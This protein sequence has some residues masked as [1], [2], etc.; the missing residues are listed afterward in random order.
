MGLPQIRSLFR[1]CIQG[2]LGAHPVCHRQQK[3]ARQPEKTPVHP[4]QKKSQK[5]KQNLKD[6]RPRRGRR[7]NPSPQ[8]EAKD[9][10]HGKKSRRKKGSP[11]SAHPDGHQEEGKGG[12]AEGVGKVVN[13]QGRLAEGMPTQPGGAKEE[14]QKAKPPGVTPDPAPQAKNRKTQ[15]CQ[16]K[17]KIVGLAH[18][19]PPQW[20]IPWGL[21]RAVGDKVQNCFNHF[22]VKE[23]PPPYGNID[24]PQQ[25]RD[26]NPAGQDPACRHGKAAP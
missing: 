8:S 7:R 11:A 6:K 1:I 21:L 24:D 16:R 20:L 19:I 22:P 25:N 13:V 17:S 3:E 4:Q 9:P 18:P 26:E 2:R 14:V 23:G 12:Q 10:G 5:K 15:S